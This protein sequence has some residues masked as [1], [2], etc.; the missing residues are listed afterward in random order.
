MWLL[1]LT[2]HQPWH[3]WWWTNRLLSGKV[4]FVLTS[5][6]LVAIS[7]PQPVPLSNSSLHHLTHASITHTAAYLVCISLGGS[8]ESILD[9]RVDEWKT[10]LPIFGYHRILDMQCGAGQHHLGLFA[11]CSLG[12]QNGCQSMIWGSSVYVN[13]LLFS[14]LKEK[15][16]FKGTCP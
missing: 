8:H 15:I 14:S 16:N 13:K 5:M 3:H 10:T 9:E 1:S 4:F 11:L 6:G 7:E 12:L 2:T